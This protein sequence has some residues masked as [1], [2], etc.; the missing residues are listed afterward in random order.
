VPAVYPRGR[1]RLRASV[2]AFVVSSSLAST[3]M[4]GLTAAPAAAAPTTSAA[5]GSA[6][7]VAVELSASHLSLTGFESVTAKTAL[8][9]K[10]TRKPVTKTVHTDGV[11]AKHKAK[12]KTSKHKAKASKHKAKAKAT[13][14]KASHKVAAQLSFGE[15]VI[16][17][18]SRYNGTPYE[19]GA[20][21]PSRFDCSGFTR[22]IFAK[23]GISLPHS[24]SGQYS[25]VEH[26]A[27]S[28]K[29]IGDLVFFHTGSGHVYHVGIYAGGDEIEAATHT[30]DFVRLEGMWS[31]SYYVGRIT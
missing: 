29:R 4:V 30:G 15:R 23:F 5:S 1:V 6:G 28:Q 9:H 12:A 31:A 11:K 24:S 22:F 26:V 3:V 2:F 10:I 25:M 21:G 16:R 18:A 27:N 14:H 20:S 7:I 13:K 17:E 19:Y 8:T